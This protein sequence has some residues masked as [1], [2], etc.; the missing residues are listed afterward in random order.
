MELPSYGKAETKFEKNYSYSV[1]GRDWLVI[2]AKLVRTPS[3]NWALPS[4][5]IRRVHTLVAKALREQEEALNPE[6]EAF[7]ANWE[8]EVA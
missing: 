7:L 1:A 5:E 3:G 2:R 6:E 8:Y 4:T